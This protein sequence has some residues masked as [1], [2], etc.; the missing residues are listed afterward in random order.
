M[1][2]RHEAAIGLVLAAS[3]GLILAVMLW[4]EAKARPSLDDD[5]VSAD[6]VRVKSQPAPRPAPSASLKAMR[7]KAEKITDGGSVWSTSVPRVL[8]ELGWGAG[9]NQLG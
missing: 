2:G 6:P 9:K 7:A 4:P 5:E 1:N 8:A 3:A